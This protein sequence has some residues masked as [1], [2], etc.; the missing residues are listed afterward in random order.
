MKLAHALVLCKLFI[1][2]ISIFKLS[3]KIRVVLLIM[4][5][6]KISL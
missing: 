5:A 3:V 1:Y 4:Y 2:S 6:L